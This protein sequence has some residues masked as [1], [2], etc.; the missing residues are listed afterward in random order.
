MK[1]KIFSA[2]LLGACISALP[3]TRVCACGSYA[4]GKTIEYRIADPGEGVAIDCCKG[5]AVGTQNAFSFS[6]EL[7][8]DGNYVMTDS[9]TYPS[10]AAAQKDCCPESTT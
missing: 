3:Q 7:S 4:S 10:S 9:Y 2:L 5:R 1:K 6:W 8:K